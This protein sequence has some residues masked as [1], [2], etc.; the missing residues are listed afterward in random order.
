MDAMSRRA[1]I[2]LG[3]VGALGMVAV[4]V[5]IVA[6]PIPHVPGGGS[7]CASGGRPGGPYAIQSITETALWL[8]LV[9]AL[10]IV[11]AAGALTGRLGWGILVSV[12]TALPVGAFLLVT[13]FVYAGRIDCAF[14]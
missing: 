10:A 3:V 1:W 9:A 13:A 7:W 2:W 4:F 6:Y 11:V 8:D 12:L 5:T 14:Y